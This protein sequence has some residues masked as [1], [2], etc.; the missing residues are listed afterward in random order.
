M[1]GNKNANVFP[2]PVAEIP[3]MSRP[4]NAIGHPWL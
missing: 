1:A 4:N 2:D 3:I